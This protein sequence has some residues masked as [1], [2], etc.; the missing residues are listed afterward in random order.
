MS[1]NVRLITG[2]RENKRVRRAGSRNTE[3]AA[4]EHPR[5][6]WQ[7]SSSDSSPISASRHKNPATSPV[8]MSVGRRPFRAAT[9]RCSRRMVFSFRIAPYTTP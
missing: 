7:M 4:W 2:T 5:G 9:R 6:S 3:K 8:M 1:R